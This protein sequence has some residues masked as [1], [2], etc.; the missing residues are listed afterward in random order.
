MWIF[1]Q[2]QSGKVKNDIVLEVGKMLNIMNQYDFIVKIIVYFPPEFLVLLFF[3]P[4]I[5]VFDFSYHSRAH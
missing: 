5:F 3:L 2:H 4:P 1:S